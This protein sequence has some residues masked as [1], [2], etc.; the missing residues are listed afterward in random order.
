MGQENKSLADI[1]KLEESITDYSKIIDDI[2][3]T[4]KSIRTTM[5]QGQGVIG[6]LDNLRIKLAQPNHK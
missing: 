5:C 1:L 3:L 2:L 4:C 6:T